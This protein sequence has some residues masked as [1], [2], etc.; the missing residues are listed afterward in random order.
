M[1]NAAA[2]SLEIGLDMLRERR[3][4]IM[5]GITTDTIVPTIIVSF[6]VALVDAVAAARSANLNFVQNLDK[7]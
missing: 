4:A 3:K 1:F 5:P 7:I 6:A 2:L